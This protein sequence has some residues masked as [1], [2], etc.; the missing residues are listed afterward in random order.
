MTTN[1]FDPFIFVFN[2]FSGPFLGKKICNNT[3]EIRRIL[4]FVANFTGTGENKVHEGESYIRE[5]GLSLPSDLDHLNIF[6]SPGS[7]RQNALFC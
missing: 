2:S 3:E 7:H 1:F 6:C 5:G 4:R